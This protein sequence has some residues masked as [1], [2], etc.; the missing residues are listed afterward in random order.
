M[1]ADSVLRDNLWVAFKSLDGDSDGKLSTE[2]VGRLVSSGTLHDMGFIPSDFNVTAIMDELDTR[3]RDGMI[4][5]TEFVAYFMPSWTR[6]ETEQD[7]FSNL[8]RKLQANA[9]A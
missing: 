3:E 9:G 4:D 5:F 8:T 6:G 1:A 2:D 7:P